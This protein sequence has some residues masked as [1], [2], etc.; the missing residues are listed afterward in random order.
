MNQILGRKEVIF[1]SDQEPAITAVVE[2]V[3]E[4][5]MPARTLHTKIPH[6]SHASLGNAEQ[7]NWTLEAM[8]RTPPWLGCC[9]TRAGS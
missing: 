9:G 8:A 1:K 6:Y 2:G 7:G 3:K 4:A 5:R